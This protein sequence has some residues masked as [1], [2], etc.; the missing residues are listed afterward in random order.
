MTKK[1]FEKI[2]EGL[3]E[4]LAIAKGEAE[5]ARMHVP[6]ELD[7]RAIRHK[8]GLS[9]EE[10]ASAFG[11]T[12]SQIKQ[13]EQGRHRP[14]RA[15]RAYLLVMAQDPSMVLKML[16]TGASAQDEAAW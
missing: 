13:W 12:S 2:A 6:P 3:T 15:A 5:P 11:F 1:A 4:A 14:L 10:F 7:V 8:T 16:R 9:Q